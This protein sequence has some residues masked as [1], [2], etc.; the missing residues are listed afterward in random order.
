MK[1]IFT[2][3]VLHVGKIWEVKE[4]SSWYASNFLFPKKLA[5][6]YTKQVEEGIEKGEQKKE[7]ERRILLWN[8][9]ELVDML[10]GEV[11][12]FMLK[13][14]W[15]KVYGSILPKDIAEYISNKYKIPVTK[16]HIDLW[17]LHS[18]LKTLGKHDIYVN[19][20]ENYAA[21]AIAEITLQ[22]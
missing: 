16:K 10:V 15:N 5:K 3:H 6:P 14:S 9:Q 12:P 1:V 18:A 22:A 2:Q 17:G 20:G 4:V 7:S 8:K 19:F 11:F 13:G 21:K